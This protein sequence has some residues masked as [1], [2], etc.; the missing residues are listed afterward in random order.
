MYSYNGDETFKTKFVGGKLVPLKGGINGS[1][2]D[3]LEDATHDFIQML[4]D[5]GS[6]AG[7]WMPYAKKVELYK[8]YRAKHR[9][10]SVGVDTEDLEPAK[11]AAK[12]DKRV[13]ALGARGW[14]L[15]AKEENGD[16][17]DMVFTKA[18]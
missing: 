10:K 14:K 2:E 18:P 6:A 1:D 4:D 11:A 7:M 15:F 13:I 8:L 9:V 5:E 16:Y 3:R 12:V 17:V